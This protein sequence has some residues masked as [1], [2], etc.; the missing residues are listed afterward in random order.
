MSNTTKPNTSNKTSKT[1]TKKTKKTSSKRPVSSK[2]ISLPGGKKFKMNFVTWVM[3]ITLIFLLILVLVTMPNRS[4]K[5]HIKS[6]ESKEEIV[7]YCTEKDL[8]CTFTV[9]SDYD[10]EGYKVTRV[11]ILQDD[12]FD[13]EVVED[14]TASDAETTK[15]KKNVYITVQKGQSLEVPSES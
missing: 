11:S 12:F 5:N 8:N 2:H 1:K 10:I 9:L 15:P 7:E 14:E 3:L 6:L 13:A 4:I